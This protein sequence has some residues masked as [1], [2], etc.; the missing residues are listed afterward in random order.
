DTR[1]VAPQVANGTRQLVAP[2][3][4][5]AEPEGDRR[6]RSLRVGDAD[7][8]AADLQDLP[9]GVAELEDVAGGALDGEILVERAD[10]GVV[11]LEDDLVI[12]DLRNRA[13]R[14]DG[15]HPRAA[16]SAHAAVHLVAVHERAA[17]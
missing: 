2:R 8:A 12:R 9:R 17:P 5:L 13:A 15:E 14:G 16:A 10:H 7:G 6:R 1:D 4:C 11:R 3:G